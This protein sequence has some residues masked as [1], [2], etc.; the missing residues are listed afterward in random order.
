[1]AGKRDYYDVLGVSREASQDEIKKAY[2]KM[3]LKYH[4][5]VHPDKEEAEAKFKEI[6]EAYEVLSDSQKRATYDRFGHSAFDRARAGGFGGGGF[7]FGDLGWE[8]LKT[9]SICFSGAVTE[10]VVGDRPELDRKWNE[11]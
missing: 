4:P 7:D 11:H 9:F 6:N 3:A 8:D 2:R 1:M 10:V 5:D